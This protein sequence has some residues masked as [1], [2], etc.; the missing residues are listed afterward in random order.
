MRKILLGLAVTAAIAS[1]LATAAAA[2]AAVP[3][4]KRYANCTAMHAVYPHGVAKTLAASQRDGHGAPVRP[5]V[6]S[7]N[8]GSDRDHDSVA[9][10]A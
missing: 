8:S 2:D 1:P 7:L 4:P 10:E 6:Y 3:K 5:V 9:C